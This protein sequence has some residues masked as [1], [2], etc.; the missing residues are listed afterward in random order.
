MASSTA[1]SLFDQFFKVLN[2][3]IK[4]IGRRPHWGYLYKVVEFLLCHLT[5]RVHV[6]TAIH[7]HARLDWKQ[8]FHSLGLLT[9]LLWTKKE[10]VKLGSFPID[11]LRKI[12]VGLSLWP[13]DMY[14]KIWRVDENSKF[15]MS[16][17]GLSK[18][19]SLTSWRNFVSFKLHLFFTQNGWMK[20]YLGFTRD[21]TNF[22]FFLN[23]GSSTYCI[24]DSG[25][26][27]DGRETTPPRSLSRNCLIF[28][29]HMFLACILELNLSAYANISR[30]WWL[31]YVLS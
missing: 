23:P 9:S 26:L 30:E 15:N 5:P 16:I 2:L 13:V 17:G 25:H 24:I 20:A 12:T 19:S 27:M 6:S 4:Q 21:P 1:F 31:L 11:C 7:L 3:S 10:L 28:S 18:W 8:F 14:N 22:F 29:F